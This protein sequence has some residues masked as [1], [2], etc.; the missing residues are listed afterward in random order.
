MHESI[1][2]SGFRRTDDVLQGSGWL[3]VVKSQDQVERR[4]RM[5]ES[6]KGGKIGR[7]AERPTAIG[8]LTEVR[9]DKGLCSTGRTLEF[10]E[11]RHVRLH[12]EGGYV[13]TEIDCVKRLDD[14][15]RVMREYRHPFFAFLHTVDLSPDGKRML[16]V[17]SGYDAC[18][19]FD[20]ESGEIT[21]EWFAWDHGFNPDGDGVWLAT[22][23]AKAAQYE[24]EGKKVQLIDPSQ[25][26]EQG[27]LTSKRTAHPNVAVYD[28][29]NDGYVIICIAHDGKLYRV[30]QA[31]GDPECV[32]SQLNQMPHGLQ[33]Y[34]D[35]WLMTNTTVGEWWVFSSDWQPLRR[36]SLQGL[37]GKITGTEDMEWLQQVVSV[38][39]GEFLCLDANR[40]VLAVDIVEKVYSL[41]QPN[42]NWCIQDA[43]LLNF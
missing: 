25:F 4:R 28:R 5:L 18:F 17:S 23:S 39:T 32:C 35:G 37:T 33:P 1:D 14:E 43:M 7:I 34:Q 31:G 38:P 11:P 10:R 13:I 40:G 27:I 16:V 42:P 3:L 29:Y 15:G 21:W 8:L 12:P 30:A 19:E 41:Y 24:R 36:V 2:I 6:R 20:L 26:G 22:S 9:L